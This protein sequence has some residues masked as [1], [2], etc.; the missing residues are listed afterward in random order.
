MIPTLATIPRCDTH[1]YTL[2]TSDGACPTCDALP[3]IT[4]GDHAKADYVAEQERKAHHWAKAS[5]RMHD[6]PAKRR[7]RALLASE[8][9]RIARLAQRAWEP[10]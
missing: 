5:G 3:W 8:A 4:V 7:Q 2:L 10:V 6:D 1:R 9:S